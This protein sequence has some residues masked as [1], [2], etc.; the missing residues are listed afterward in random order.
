[1]PSDWESLGRDNRFE[2]TSA[3][4]DIRLHDLLCELRQVTGNP[5]ADFKDYLEAWL[6]GSGCMSIAI[7]RDQIS[8]G[9]FPPQISEDDVMKP[10]FRVATFYEVATSSY[11][12]MP[13]VTA[14]VS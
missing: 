5:N 7:L 2:A 14:K 4:G 12:Y 11:R 13:G 10:S 8:Q 6:Q 3:V 9:V 1:M